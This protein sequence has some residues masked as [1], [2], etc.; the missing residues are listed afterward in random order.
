MSRLFQSIKDLILFPLKT[1]VTNFHKII[2]I[3]ER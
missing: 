3:Q 1:I 2:S